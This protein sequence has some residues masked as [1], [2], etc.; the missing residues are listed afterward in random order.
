MRKIVAIA[1]LIAA[2]AMPGRANP[3]TPEQLK[4]IDAICAKTACRTGGY[5]VAVGV[6]ATHF[7][8]VP[9]SRSPYVTPNDEILIFPGETIAVQFTVTG[10]TLSAPRFLK[11]YATPKALAMK[12]DTGSK[13]VD[14]P[15]NASLLPVQKDGDIDMAGLPPNTLL[16]TYGQFSD[17]IGMAMNLD[18]N[19]PRRLKMDASLSLIKTGSYQW[20]YTS[21][22]PLASGRGSYENWPGALGPM[23]LS[24]FRF[25]SHDAK[26]T[27]E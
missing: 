25:L 20:H 15:L 5:D 3:P 18:T 17:H 12:L 10:D 9:V 13:L 14:A 23:R 16:I 4:Q 22:C 6:D 7:T 27:C 24:H 21:T 1:S 19:L 8:D 2:M 26:D 11:Q